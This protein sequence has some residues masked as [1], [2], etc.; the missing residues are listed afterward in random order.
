MEAGVWRSCLP[1]A[2][3]QRPGRALRAPVRCSGELWA[4]SLARTVEPPAARADAPHPAASD[5]AMESAP[6]RSP[7]PGSSHP[8][9]EPHPRWPP[10]ARCSLAVR[11]TRPLSG[12]GELCEPRSAAAGSYGPRRSPA[13]VSRTPLALITPTQR[14][15]T[16][17]RSRRRAA[18]LCTPRPTRS[19][20]RIH[21]GSPQPVAL[22]R[23]A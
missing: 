7:V 2:P 13:P 22:S 12:R 21:D 14:R 15:A 20:S 18:P 3:A 16:T 11:I 1:N 6:R 10:S 4:P 23:C 8:F 9:Y 19:M 5:Q 17:P